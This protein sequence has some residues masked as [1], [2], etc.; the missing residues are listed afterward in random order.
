MQR[1]T[2]VF[3]GVHV[4]AATSNSDALGQHVP[5]SHATVLRDPSIKLGTQTAWV[6]RST[7]AP[8]QH[9]PLHTMASSSNVLGV[10]VCRRR[11]QLPVEPVPRSAAAAA[12][13]A[14]IDV[15]EA[16]AELRADL[17]SNALLA[18]VL[19]G[20]MTCDAPAQHSTAYHMWQGVCNIDMHLAC[21][22]GS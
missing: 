22:A 12:A 6:C 20:R 19:G 18:P 17:M 9:P 10:P 2:G 14:A 7:M 8:L 13:L 21:A 1:F 16:D 3:L 11:Y 5:T 15:Q 4:A